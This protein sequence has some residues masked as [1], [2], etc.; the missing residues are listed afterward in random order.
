MD[1]SEVSELAQAT[2]AW[3]TYKDLTGAKG[4]L[5]EASLSM[6]ILEFLTRK[7]I[8]EILREVPHPNFPR[9]GRGR[10]KQL[11]F[12]ARR[13]GVGWVFVLETKFGRSSPDSLINDI[14]RLALLP[15]ATAKRFLLLS[16]DLRMPQP[17]FSYQ[18]Y[19]GDNT[20][21]QDFFDVVLR[22]RPDQGADQ[23]FIDLRNIDERFRRKF[24]AFQE[25]YR[26]PN[27]PNMLNLFHL[28][29]CSTELY[30]THIWQISMRQGTGRSDFAGEMTL[31]EGETEAVVEADEQAE[32]NQA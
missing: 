24:A 21:G 7:T 5:N 3:L 27:L 20:P 17:P 19:R 2:T 31:T 28:A 18:V 8:F 16:A 10:P 23:H 12:V 14:M 26:Q 11:D 22:W 30:A 32:S 29:S 25:A 1:Q 4:L 6:P 13:S 9:V 15:S